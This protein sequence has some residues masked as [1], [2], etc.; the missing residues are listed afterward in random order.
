[1]APSPAPVLTI[2]GTAR[3]VELFERVENQET[4]ESRQ[5]A[6]VQILTDLGG[7]AE[8]YVDPDH[9][10]TLPALVVEAGQEFHPFPVAWQVEVSAW[11]RQYRGQDQV[12]PNER[13]RYAS[14]NLR[15]RSEASPSAV[16]AL[17]PRESAAA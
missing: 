1:M 15:F 4:G 17:R 13:R 16:H 12:P 8:V 7:F 11:Q 6:R 5:A 10:A 3:S 9:L 14:L 2:T